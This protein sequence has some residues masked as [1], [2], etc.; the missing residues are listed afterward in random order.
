MLILSVTQVNRYLALKFKED[1][2][3]HG[4]MIRGEISNFSAHRSG[5]FYFTLKDKEGKDVSLSD[6]LGKKV[7]VYFY[8][9]DNTPGCTRQ[10]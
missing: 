8:P 2:K 5:H 9:K 1:T 6:F 7:V 10:A 3:L 4:V